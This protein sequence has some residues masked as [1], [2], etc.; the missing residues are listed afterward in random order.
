MGGSTFYG[1]VMTLTFDHQGHGDLDLSVVVAD[2]ECVFAGVCQLSS[3]DR[4][5]CGV[6]VL[7][8]GQRDLV[9]TDLVLED[10]LLFLP[11]KLQWKIIDEL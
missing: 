11:Y 3:L 9:A 10:A 1:V 8:L 7:N 6:G 5:Y 2:K 4:Q